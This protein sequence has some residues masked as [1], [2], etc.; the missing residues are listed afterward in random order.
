MHSTKKLSSLTRHCNLP[1]FAA[2]ETITNLTKYELTQEECDL[3]KAGLYISIQPDKIQKS[4]IFTTFQKIHRS[5]LKNLKSEESISQ[6]KVHLLYLANCHFSS[7]KPSPP[8]LR[9]Q[10]VLWNLGKNKDNVIAKPDKGNGAVILDRKLLKKLFQT[11]LNSKSSVKT[12]P[13]NPKLHY[14]VFYISWNKKTFLMKLDMVNC[15]LLTLL[16]LIYMVLLKCTNSPL[17]IHF[18]NFDCFIYRYFWLLSC[19]F[20]LWSYFAFSS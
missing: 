20:P 13:W 4:E 16:L 14:Y 1:T 8:I 18:L 19:L 7:Y 11:L 6:I 17:V 12:Q 5:F 15:I 2:N 3:L 9:Q 10:R